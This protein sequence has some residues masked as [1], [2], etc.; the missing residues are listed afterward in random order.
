MGDK[1]IKNYS[2]KPSSEE[3]NPTFTNLP[4]KKRSISGMGGGGGGGLL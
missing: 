1:V 4:Y 2:P 3:K